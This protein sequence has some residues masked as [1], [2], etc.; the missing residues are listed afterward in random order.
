MTTSQSTAPE[1]E[2]EQLNRIIAALLEQIES[3]KYDNEALI[4]YILQNVSL[5]GN[6][7]KGKRLPEPGLSY[8]EK[9]NSLQEPRYSFAEK[10]K[11]ITESGSSLTENDKGIS[12]SVP[13]LAE[14]E[15]GITE[16]SFSHLEKG[17]GITELV[18]SLIEKYKGISIANP[19]FVDNVRGISTLSPSLPEKTN[20]QTEADYV[21][22]NTINT[23]GG[24]VSSLYLKLRS[25]AFK[26]SQWSTRN[27]AAKLLIHLYNKGNGSYGS[28]KSVTGYSKGGLGKF[29]MNMRQKGLIISTG[30]QQW[31]PSA[32]ALRLMKEARLK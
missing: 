15:M 30:Y 28:L 10:D 12:T 14:N 7:E 25:T 4:K 20:Q 23:T 24:N 22:P 9:V 19:S 13:S 3:L 1:K 21:L 29:M 5:L 6:S 17:K 31:Y 11:G 16:L 8:L 27:A 18:Y 32:Y 2:I 26:V